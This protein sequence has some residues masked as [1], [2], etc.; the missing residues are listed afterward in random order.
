MAWTAKESS[1]ESIEGDT[2]ILLVR[3][4]EI[5]GG[6]HVLTGQRPD[7]WEYSQLEQLTSSICCKLSRRVLAQEN[8]ESTEKV[9]EIDQQVDLEMQELTRRVLQGCSAINRLTRETFLHVVKSFCYVAYCS[10]ETIDSHIDKVIFQD[11]I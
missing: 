3:A 2:A 10:P 5:F 11:V 1:Q 7:L 6:R 8:G 9:E 4:I